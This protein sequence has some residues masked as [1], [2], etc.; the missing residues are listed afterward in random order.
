MITKFIL[1]ENHILI[2]D[3]TYGEIQLNICYH[4]RNRY[5]GITLLCIRSVMEFYSFKNDNVIK[6]LFK[7]I[8]L[9]SNNRGMSMGDLVC[10]IKEYDE[11]YSK[12]GEQLEKYMLLL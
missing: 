2:I 8:M 9:Y 5:K 10:F 4:A 3:D 1:N 6:N 12:Y 7:F 11:E